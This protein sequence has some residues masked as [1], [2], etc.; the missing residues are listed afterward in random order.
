[1]VEPHLMS[2]LPLETGRVRYYVSHHVEHILL[3]RLGCHKESYD[4]SWISFGGSFLV[5]FFGNF[6]FPL[7][8]WIDRLLIRGKYFVENLTMT[9]ENR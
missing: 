5:L 2:D 9:R 8:P 3:G 4:R 1:M 7:R 6:R